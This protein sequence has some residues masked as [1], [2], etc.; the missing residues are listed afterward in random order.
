MK[1]TLTFSKK[2]LTQQQYLYNILQNYGKIKSIWTDEKDSESYYKT[3]TEEL[4]DNERIFMSFL[5]TK[6]IVENTTQNK[7]IIIYYIKDNKFGWYKKDNFFF[8]YPKNWLE[9][10]NFNKK[11]LN[12]N[13]KRINKLNRIFNDG[14]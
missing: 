9:K 6:P 13:Y 5:F 3:H 14:S 1:K 12:I 11:L 8:L 2:Y 10:V 7:I 4:E